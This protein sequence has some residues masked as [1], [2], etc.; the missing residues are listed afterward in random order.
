VNARRLS[1]L[2]AAASLVLAVPTTTVFA[3][4]P[5]FDPTIRALGPGQ[6][7][8]LGTIGERVPGGRLFHVERWYNGGVPATPILI[9]FKEGEAIGD[10]SYPVS[11]GTRL[12]IAPEM[13]AG[14]RLSANLATIQADPDT[15]EGRRWVEEATALFGPGV[16][17]EPLAREPFTETGIP[18]L[19]IVAA[20][21]L[22]L[23][24]AV[25]GA[26]VRH[27]ALRGGRN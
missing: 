3:C 20:A 26:T 16:V 8:V 23:L 25:V 22:G 21:L 13:E 14:S 10:C 11:A 9:A 12:I 5:P 24:G 19:V 27:R 18:P 1:A 17:P 4:S 15:P 7:V 6:I 2:L